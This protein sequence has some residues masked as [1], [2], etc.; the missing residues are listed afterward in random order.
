MNLFTVLIIMMGMKETQKNKFDKTR[1]KSP[2]WLPSDPPPIMWKAD[3]FLVC[4]RTLPTWERKLS[5]LN[6][7]NAERDAMKRR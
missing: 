5:S 2:G 7:R 6:K 4:K 1:K 3:C